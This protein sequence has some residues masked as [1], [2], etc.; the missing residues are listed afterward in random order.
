MLCDRCHK[1]EAG[2][3]YKHIIAGKVSELYLCAACAAEIGAAHAGL[4]ADGLFG[5][6]FGKPQPA[7]R[8]DSGAEVRRCPLCGSSFDDLVRTGKAGCEECYTFFAR[9]LA[10]TISSIHGTARHRGRLPEKLSGAMPPAPAPEPAADA[11]AGREHALEKELAAAV[12]AQEYERAAVLRDELRALRGG[13][14]HA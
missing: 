11:G 2:I 8:E 10:P 13:E 4:T 3:H 6:L 14:Q 12:E 9:E 7:Q 5:A 1:N